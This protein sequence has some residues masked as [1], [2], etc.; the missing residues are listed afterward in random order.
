MET[1]ARV[2]EA[3]SFS[4]AA[5]RLGLSK[6]AVSKAIAAL[7]EELGSRLL[8]R[9]TR[10]V[11]LTEAGEVFLRSCQN[12]V[13]EA[14]RAERAVRELSDSPRGLL[15]VNTAT[16]FA[17]RWLA[18]ALPA[19]FERH[20]GVQVDLEGIDTYVDAAH[21][22]WD[23]VIR[24]GRLVDSG[25]ITRKLAHV[26]GVIV[27]S[28]AYLARRGEPRRPEDLREHDCITYSLSSPP[29]RWTL[30]RKSQ[31]VA[32][33]VTGHLRTNLDGA[34]VSAL[35]AGHGVGMLPTFAVANEL[36]TGQLQAVLTG[37]E[38]PPLVMHALMPPAVAGTAKVR[39]FVDFL[40]ERFARESFWE[41]V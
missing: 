23:V 38:F 15:R 20:P 28:P 36:R 25:L 6:G 12:I 22:G 39:A 14:E 9:S 32:L 8:N 19:F 4:T 16:A 3:R 1:F 27:A 11:T 34:C 18:P 35:V 37:W 13:A 30:T 31:K 40:V 26:R 33:R 10:N 17:A 41:A 5:R 2:A 7:E 21:G 24:I 29:D